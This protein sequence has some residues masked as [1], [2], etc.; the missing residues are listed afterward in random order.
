MI[1]I[2]T[3]LGRWDTDIQVYNTHTHKIKKAHRQDEGQTP[4]Q[5]HSSIIKLGPQPVGCKLWS[6]SI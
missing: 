1:E 4:A 6:W 3:G 5:K 2:I